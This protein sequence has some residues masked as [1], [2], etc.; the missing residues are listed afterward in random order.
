MILPQKTITRLSGFIDF[1]SW[2]LA[3]APARLSSIVGGG[4][5]PC[6]RVARIA[7]AGAQWTGIWRLPA[8]RCPQLLMGAGWVSPPA[9]RGSAVEWTSEV[10][11]VRQRTRFAATSPRHAD[12]ARMAKIHSVHIAGVVFDVRENGFSCCLTAV[13]AVGP[14]RRVVEL[15][16]SRLACWL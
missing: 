9:I 16:Q 14:Q 1:H 10:E 4:A 13:A 15:H 6:A 11:I 8:R 2:A 12:A 7:R 5:Q 3:K